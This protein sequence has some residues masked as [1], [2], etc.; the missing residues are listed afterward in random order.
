M[1]AICN[2]AN[3]GTTASSD[4]IDQ[5]KLLEAMKNYRPHSVRFLSA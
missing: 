3:S 1:S 2:A 5:V 4:E